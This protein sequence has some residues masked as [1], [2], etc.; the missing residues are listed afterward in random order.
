MSLGVFHSSSFVLCAKPTVL[1]GM[2]DEGHLGELARW[3]EEEFR[4]SH[5]K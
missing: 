4:R 3:G 2:I 5:W 1:H